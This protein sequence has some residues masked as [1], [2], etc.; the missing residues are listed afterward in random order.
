MDA[1]VT[2][3]KR[4]YE[5]LKRQAAAWRHVVGAAPGDTVIFNAVRDNGGVGIE[6]G[7]FAEKLRAIGHE[8]LRPEVVKRLD[9][10]SK[11]MDEGKGIRLANMKEYRAFIKSL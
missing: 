3:S 1:K 9:R 7:V 11:L 2:I 4:R 6:A 8:E 10:Q 5:A